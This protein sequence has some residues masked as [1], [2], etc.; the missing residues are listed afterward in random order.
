MAGVQVDLFGLLYGK[1]TF[2]PFYEFGCGIL[3]MWL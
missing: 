2:S 1:V 3:G